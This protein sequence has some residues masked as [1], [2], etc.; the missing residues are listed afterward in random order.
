MLAVVSP[1]P[2]VAASEPAAAI[3]DMMSS[4]PVVERRLRSPILIDARP[5]SS[6]RSLCNPPRRRRSVGP[7]RRRHCVC[8]DCHIESALHAFD[9]LPWIS[10]MD[11]PHHH[12]L[13]DIA[14]LS[15]L[16]V[17]DFPPESASAGAGPIRRRK[18]SLRSNP[19]APSPTLHETPP[20]TPIS[21]INHSRIHFENLM[22]VFSCD[23]H[24]RS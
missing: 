23:H 14:D 10:V 12:N 2:C 20:H 9:R 21:H 1:Q 22:P 5:R 19:L 3:Y 8:A 4:H 6:A 24:T 7:H 17:D 16:A 11:T 18:T 15:Q 13:A